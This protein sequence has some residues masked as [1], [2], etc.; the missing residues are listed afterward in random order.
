ML[1]LCG[2]HVFFMENIAV[3][4]PCYNEEKT[5]AAVICD[6]KSILPNAAIYV[7]DNDST[8]NTVQE[9][10]NAG[11][12]VRTVRQKGK[13]NVVRRM[14]Y[15]VDAACYII[16]DGDSTYDAKEAPKLINKVM[17]EGYDMAVGDRLS[18]T[19]FKENTRMFH[20]LG[21][22]L[23]K[24]VINAVFRTDVSDVMTGYRAF[25]HRFV[26]T[27]PVL[28][29]GF[30]IETE[31]TIHAADKNLYVTSIPVK[32][33]ERKNPEDSKVSTIKD[34]IK[35]LTTI[36]RLIKDYSPFFFFTCIAIIAF[37]LA[38]SFF[39]P[40]FIDFLNTGEVLRFPTLIVCCF[41]ALLAAQFFIA[42]IILQSLRRKAKED[43]ELRLLAF[44]EK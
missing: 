1:L 41:V 16:V 26:K 35:I 29:S 10:L 17:L 36:F 9:A 33:K 22:R 15:E 32:Y 4:I 8:D 3:L 20:G 37:A 11:A 44:K 18:S 31:M 2:K 24:S 38:V 42:G 39:I 40:V 14:F 5:I 19:Y 25:S 28:V 12:I 6:F 27:F 30:E 13:G 34:G 43:F 7:Y 21:N 23:V